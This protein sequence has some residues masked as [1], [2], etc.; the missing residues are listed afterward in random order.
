MEFLQCCWDI[1]E[2]GHAIGAEN[3]VKAVVWEGDS[4]C[5]PKLEVNVG[6]SKSLC[7]RPRLIK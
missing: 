5:I 6:R 4:F 1:L 7:L 2:V 3:K